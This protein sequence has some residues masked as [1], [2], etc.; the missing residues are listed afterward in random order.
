MRAAPPTASF[1]FTFPWFP[2]SAWERAALQALPP[3][4]A[5]LG[6]TYQGCDFCG[7]ESASPVKSTL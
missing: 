5:S 2:G 1:R 4:G 7:E 6:T 3:V